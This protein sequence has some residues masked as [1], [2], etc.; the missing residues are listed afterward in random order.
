MAKDAA[1]T[2]R[3]P[4]ELKRRLALRAKRERRS[5][6]GQV[7]HELERAIAGEPEEHAGLA[8]AVGM[9]QGARVPAEDDFREVRGALWGSLGERDG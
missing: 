6:S 4:A 3:L 5:I 2:V 1:I 9:F 8:P 7:Q